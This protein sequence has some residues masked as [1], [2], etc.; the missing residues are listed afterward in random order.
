[1]SFSQSGLTAVNQPVYSGGQVFIS[2]LTTNPADTW[3]QV[4]VDQ[5]L[6]W[7]GQ[8][9]W[10]YLPIPPATA[11]VDIGWVPAGEEQTVFPAVCRLDRPGPRP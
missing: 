10:V 6:A 11:R 9:L 3:W 2:W 5:S 4:Y 8:R 7:F 1:M